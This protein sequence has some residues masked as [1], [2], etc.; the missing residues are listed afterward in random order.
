MPN[1]FPPQGCVDSDQD[2]RTDLN[3]GPPEHELPEV[4]ESVFTTVLSTFS[5]GRHVV[6]SISAEL[7]SVR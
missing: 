6:G 2:T 4:R 5:R 7:L 3:S 1:D